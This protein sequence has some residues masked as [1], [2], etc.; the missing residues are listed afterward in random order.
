MLARRE[1]DQDRN[2]PGDNPVYRYDIVTR[3]ESETP[4]FLD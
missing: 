4:F 3:G 2:G 1:P